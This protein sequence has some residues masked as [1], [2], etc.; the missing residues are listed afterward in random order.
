MRA[1]VTN[2]AMAWAAAAAAAVRRQLFPL[3][4]E[5]IDGYEHPEL[6][7]LIFQ[8]TKAYQP[9]ADWPEISG[10]SSVLDFGG[11]CGLHYKQA[12]LPA[13]R[14][15]VVDTPAMVARAAELA[16][17]RLRFFSSIDAAADW[18]GPIDVMHSNGA[19]QYT[20]DPESILRQLCR[21]RAVRMIW[22]R[23][24]FGPSDRQFSLLSSN[25]PGRYA[26]REKSV[27]YPRIGISEATFIK[28]HAGYTLEHR[29]D[30]NFLFAAR[31]DPPIGI[32][33][34]SNQDRTIP[35]GDPRRGV[36]Q[37]GE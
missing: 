14:W 33:E 24:Y 29:Q 1:E 12:R 35:V 19:L 10:A 34:R 2:Q 20:P 17:D 32:D 27:S 6:V 37:A 25:G 16:T 3:P 28:A 18:L 22:K 8:K 31:V 26:V 30:D 5:R 13:A 4:K 21:L 23:V 9:T 15:A 36:G 11:A 7:E